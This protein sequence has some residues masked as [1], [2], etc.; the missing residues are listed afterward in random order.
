MATMQ[1][2][3]LFATDRADLRPGAI[4]KLRPLASYLRANPGIRVAITGHTDSRGT[5]AHNQ[6]LSERRA[7]AVKQFLIDKYRLAPE[8][9]VTAGYGKTRLKDKANPRAAENRRVEIVN[10]VPK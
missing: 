7:D 2:D 9:L 10:M 6:D 3:V 5:D 8:N 1:E 4:D